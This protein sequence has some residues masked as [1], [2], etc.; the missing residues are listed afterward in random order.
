MSTE[1]LLDLD[2]PEGARV[3]VASLPTHLAPGTRQQ[4]SRQAVEALLLHAL[5]EADARVSHREDGAPYL[6]TRPEIHISISH[7]SHYAAVALGPKAMGVDIEEPREQ[8][9][10]VAPRV[11]SAKE[12]EECPQLDD[13]LRA[14]TI[15]EALYKL[16]PSPAACDFRGNMSIAPPAVTG[17]RARIIKE[18]DFPTPP[19]HLCLLT[20]E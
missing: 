5:G 8:L 20:D 3:L 1:V 17:H 13:L 2:F 16:H 12:L 11:L 4:A 7:S 15:K 18:I 19:A 6:A 14:W 10:R 9:R